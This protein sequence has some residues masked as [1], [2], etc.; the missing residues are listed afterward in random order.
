MIYLIC[1]AL[2][3]PLSKPPKLISPTRYVSRCVLDQNTEDPGHT[4]AYK[5]LSWSLIQALTYL[6]LKSLSNIY[7]Y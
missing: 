2:L 4:V 5:S 6:R 1:A 7:W 3:S